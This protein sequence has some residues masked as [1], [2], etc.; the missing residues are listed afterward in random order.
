MEKAVLEAKL[1]CLAEFFREPGY[2][3]VSV[4]VDPDGEVDPGIFLAEV[5]FG[6]GIGDIPIQC[7]ADEVGRGRQQCVD[8][9]LER[10]QDVAI[11][12]AAG[13]KEIADAGRGGEIP[14]VFG[15]KG[16]G[17]GVD[18][19]VVI[20]GVKSPGWIDRSEDVYGISHGVE[21]GL[22]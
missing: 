20:S 17:P 3:A 5:G 19:G 9:P 8:L 13:G 11:G 12:N 2:D 16:A 7:F 22:G 15:L 18:V 14:A 21:V 6:K 4:V 1:A 10:D